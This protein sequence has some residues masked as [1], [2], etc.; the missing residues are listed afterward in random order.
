M[1]ISA[2]RG[3]RHL[4]ELHLMENRIV[5]ISPLQRLTSL[6]GLNLIDN[7]V[8]ELPEAFLNLGMEINV[9]MRFGLVQRI[10]LADNPLGKPPLEIIKKSKEVMRAYFTNTSKKRA[11]KTRI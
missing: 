7:R 1:D 10:D 3:M 4:K 5:D 2:L 8:K 6:T 11:K 9:T